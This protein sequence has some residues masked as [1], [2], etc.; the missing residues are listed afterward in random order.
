MK[1]RIQ[2]LFRNLVIYGLGDVAPSLV[3]FLVLPV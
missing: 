1:S 3:S 2:S